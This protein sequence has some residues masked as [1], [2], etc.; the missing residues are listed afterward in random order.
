M[1]V[2]ST[3]DND[4]PGSWPSVSAVIPTKDRPELLKRAVSAVLEQDYPGDI[5]VLVVFDGTEP[6]LPEVA[7][8]PRRSLRA[9]SNNRTPGLAGNRNTGYLAAEGEYVAGCD[10][11]DEWFPDKLRLQIALLQQRPDA[12]GA[13][14]GSTFHFEGNDRE[15]PAELPE[16]TLPELLAQRHPEVHA[17]SYVFRRDVLLNDI[18]LVNEDLPASYG[19]DFELLIRATRLG[20]F[21]CVRRPLLRAYMHRSSFFADKWRTIDDALAYLIDLV[22]EFAQA[23]TGLARMEGQRAFAKA[24]SGERWA[25]VKLAVRSLRR[26][27][28]VKQSWFAILVAG[29]LVSANRVLAVARRFGR[30]I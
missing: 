22:P 29:H 12:C 19:E 1:T 18:G 10:D 20:P 28:K 17:S 23:P 2:P 24:A 11:D 21:V 9:L 30:G 26:S 3:G 6:T 13:G 8:R 5:E 14:S 16:L 27:P 7:L 4:R 15:R 25:A